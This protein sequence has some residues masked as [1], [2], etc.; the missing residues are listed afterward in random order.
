MLVTGFSILSRDLAKYG[1]I[2]IILKI[3]V[4]YT[5]FII[6]ALSPV[7]LSLFLYKNVNKFDDQIY[8]NEF[9]GLFLNLKY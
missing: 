3:S 1:G 9:G 8:K 4:S 7:L 2:G 5:V 6:L